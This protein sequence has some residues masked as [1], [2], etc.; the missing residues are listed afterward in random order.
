MESLKLS[1]TLVKIEK[2]DL[3][4]GIL[5]MNMHKKVMLFALAALIGSGVS[6]M[7]AEDSGPESRVAGAASGSQSSSRSAS[8]TYSERRRARSADSIGSNS[9]QREEAHRADANAGDAHKEPVDHPDVDTTGGKPT[10]TKTTVPN[11]DKKIS[12]LDVDAG[13]TH[14]EPVGRPKGIYFSNKVEWTAA[15]GCATLSVLYAIYTIAT[16]AQFVEGA[17][18]GQKVKAVWDNIPVFFKSKM[19]KRT[20]VFV[21]CSMIPLV[22]KSVHAV[23][24]PCSSSTSSDTS[25]HLKSV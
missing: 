14:K 6:G 17:T 25:E 4:Q 1:R 23:A 13:G 15:G 16:T 22:I 19:N 5:N 11:T 18:L 9:G 24:G 12:K 8:P 20:K 10:E 3:K 7:E 2:I 21:M